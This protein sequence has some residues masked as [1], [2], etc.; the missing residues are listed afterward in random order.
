MTK[1]KRIRITEPAPVE[2]TASDLVRIW[3]ETVN[4]NGAVYP[5]GKNLL[6]VLLRYHQDISGT[7]PEIDTEEARMA[8]LMIRS[9]PSYNGRGKL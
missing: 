4:V 3:F 9:H 8:M 5:S 2:Y 6:A 7:L 1:R